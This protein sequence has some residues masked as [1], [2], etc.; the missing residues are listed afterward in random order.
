MKKLTSRAAFLI[1]AG[2]LM[3]SPAFAVGYYHKPGADVGYWDETAYWWTNDSY[4]SPLGSG[5]Q[6]NRGFLDPATLAVRT[7]D[8]TFDTFAAGAPANSATPA[9]LRVENGGLA[10]FNDVRIGTGIWGTFYGAVDVQKGGLLRVKAGTPFLV[11]AG[12]GGQG[13]V[14]NAGT[15]RFF[16]AR[17]DMVV[18]KDAGSSGKWVQN[19]G[20]ITWDYER[21]I[22]VGQDGVGELI[23]VTDFTMSPRD[24]TVE[25]CLLVG[26]GTS[27]SGRGTVT[28]EEG[29]TFR[30]Y[31]A[32]LGG[33][34]PSA[35]GMLSSYFGGV[36][37]VAGSGRVVLRGG[38]LKS[39]SN[40]GRQAGADSVWIGAATNANGAVRADSHGEIRGWGKV[41]ITDSVYE[42]KGVW[43]R[44]GNGAI[45]A[46]GEGVER[47]LDCS[48]V[49]QVTNVLFVSETERTNG[50]YAVNKGALL[51]PTVDNAYRF[52]N[53]SA[54]GYYDSAACI[55]CDPSLAKPDLVNAVR[56]HA[57]RNYM[58]KGFNMAAMLLAPDRTDVHADALHS[59]YLPIGFWKAGTFSSR[60]AQTT[61]EN[62]WDFTSADIDF[63]YDHRKV[64]R[65]DSPIV[66]LRW[67]A[68]AG[69]WTKVAKYVVQPADCIVS[70]GAMTTVNADAES[71]WSLGLFCVAELS[72][73]GFVLTVQ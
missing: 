70:S 1:S 53:S 46:D 15:V 59:K 56:I 40:R 29:S 73:T 19:G 28:I 26:C 65:S 43:A 57:Q 48:L 69:K 31:E 33:Y 47:T 51:F 22:V 2:V 60:T 38:T 6:V 45:V 27:G 63:R 54:Y 42:N 71:P 10:T 32:Y 37:S 64:R 17:P 44:L 61:V 52:N 9:T 12:S 30:A 18:G 50:W 13:V 3:A 62:R 41:D 25:G 39:V 4:T 23:A 7:T 34:S 58:Q 67:D 11:G 21:D 72:P 68:S 35:V 55:G 49:Y 14:T 36:V 8:V 16:N 5:T 20:A 24:A 66:V